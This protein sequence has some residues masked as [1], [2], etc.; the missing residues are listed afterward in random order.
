MN[1]N[2]KELIVGTPTLKT[3]PLFFIVAG[4][5]LLIITIVT[6]WSW[7][8]LAMVMYF[9]SPAISI[10]GIILYIYSGMC[11]ITVTDKRVY[12]KAGFGSRVDLPL[13]MIS[14]VGTTGITHGVQV[15]TSSGIIKFMYIGNSD[16]IHAAINNLLLERQEKPKA[17]NIVKQEVQRSDADELKKY[18][19]LLD[20]GVITQEEFDAKKKQLLGL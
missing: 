9:V 12:G 11:S 18:N 1:N 6:G 14:A 20:S 8:D 4:I 15:A 16:E 2:E 7:D 13:D 17:A 10:V 5:I 19:E 3:M